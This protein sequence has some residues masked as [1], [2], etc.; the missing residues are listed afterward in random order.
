[1]IFDVALIIIVIIFKII[2]EMTIK[3]IQIVVLFGFGFRG[4]G[5]NEWV[6]VQCSVWVCIWVC[7]GVGINQ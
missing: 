7:V 6:G 5:V 2:N 3:L 1:M 4:N